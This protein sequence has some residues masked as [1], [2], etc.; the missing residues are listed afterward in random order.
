MKNKN[1]IKEIKR[2]RKIMG[3]NEEYIPTISEDLN[4][5]EQPNSYYIQIGLDEITG[6]ILTMYVG[7]SINPILCEGEE[8]YEFSYGYTIFDE[9]HK[10]LSEKL[11]TRKDEYDNLITKKLID[12]VRPSKVFMRSGDDLTDKF[13]KQSNIITDIFLEKGYEMKKQTKNPG[14]RYTYLKDKEKLD[15]KKDDFFEEFLKNIPSIEER[16]RL[17]IEGITNEI[18][19]IPNT[20]N[21]FQWM[22]TRNKIKLLSESVKG[23]KVKTNKYVYHKSNKVNRNSILSNGLYPSVGDCYKSHMEGEGRCIPAIFAT[24][25]ENKEEWFDTTWDDDIWKID[26]EIANNSWY[27]DN[28]FKDMKHPEFGDYKH[29]VTFEPVYKEALKLIHKGTGKSEF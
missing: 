25:S 10:P 11:I 24:N 22:G 19:T 13:I 20:K 21:Q 26:T 8:F 23:K 18:N 7:F 4:I 2:S 29:V 16:D 27:F 9:N 14:I 28:N 15:N 3:L 6:Y 12:K 1:L 5:N 17:I